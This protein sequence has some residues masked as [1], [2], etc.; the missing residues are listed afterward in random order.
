MF[1]RHLL[2]KESILGIIGPGGIGKTMYVL[3]I[4][5]RLLSRKQIPKWPKVKQ[6]PKKV[7][8]FTNDPEYESKKR[9]EG[10]SKCLKV[11]IPKNLILHRPFDLSPIPSNKGH[12]SNIG[13]LFGEL[14]LLAEDSKDIDL[15]VFDTLKH[16]HAVDENSNTLM[17]LVMKNIMFFA[18]ETGKPIIITHH[19]TGASYL[20]SRSGSRGATV[21]PD[22]MHSILDM[23]ESDLSTADIALLWT[24][25][26]F[27]KRKPKSFHANRKNFLIKPADSLPDYLKRLGGNQSGNTIIGLIM[28]NEKIGKSKAFEIRSQLIEAGRIKKIRKNQYEIV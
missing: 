18:R 15:F 4:C 25:A 11:N 16:F 17:G 3:E 8:F 22:E 1:I 12:Y 6:F 28:K 24:K 10:I 5:I 20:D 7:K 19:V 13:C 2:D 26:K 9:I 27:R 14:F 23:K 21:I